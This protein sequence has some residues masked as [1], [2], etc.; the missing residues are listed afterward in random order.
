MTKSLF[1]AAGAAALLAGCQSAQFN[2]GVQGALASICPI[3]EQA[4]TTFELV[5]ARKPSLDEKFGSK[6]AKAYAAISVACSN[7]S[8]VTGSNILVFVGAA[9]LAWDA[10]GAR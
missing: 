8:S 6:E 7:P 10:A 1:A 2:E 4:H 5:S 3:V 9:Y